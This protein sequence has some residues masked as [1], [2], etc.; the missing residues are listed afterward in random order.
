MQPHDDTPPVA[1][2]GLFSSGP[3]VNTTTDSTIIDAPP[4][5]LI[6]RDEMLEEI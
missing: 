3:I 1:V 2:S 6:L 5:L 4:E